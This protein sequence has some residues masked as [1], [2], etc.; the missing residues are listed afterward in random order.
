MQYICNEML[1]AIT[2]FDGNF[3]L[4]FLPIPIEMSQKCKVFALCQVP[5]TI[6]HFSLT[7]Q[8]NHFCHYEFLN[9]SYS[10]ISIFVIANLVTSAECRV[11]AR[12]EPFIF[13]NIHCHWCWHKIITTRKHCNNCFSSFISLQ[14][15]ITS[16]FWRT[17]NLQL[18]KS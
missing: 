4:L 5:S 16:Y 10:V 11:P 8:Y 13:L 7:M 12:F 14:V 15:K 18:I 9:Y 6:A 1:N 2:I 17:H 3:F